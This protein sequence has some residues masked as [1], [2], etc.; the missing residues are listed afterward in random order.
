MWSLKVSQSWKLRVFLGLFWAYFSPGACAWTSRFP[1]ICVSF[2]KHLFTHI[3]FPSFFFPRLFN[4]SATC[5]LSYSLTQTAAAIPSI[6]LN[7]NVFNK[8]YLEGH[9]RLENIL[10][11]TSQGATRQVKTHNYN[12]LRTR[13]ILP[14]LTS[15][16]FTRNTGHHLYICHCAGKWGM[17]GRKVKMTI[18]SQWN[19]ITPLVIVIF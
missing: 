7:L 11:P 4:P 3:F 19:L 2:P 10:E 15:A 6:Y 12:S 13:P 8:C 16:N 14:P 18:L 5:L 17:V 1:G 9:F